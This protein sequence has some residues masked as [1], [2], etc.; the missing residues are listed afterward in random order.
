MASTQ[1]QLESNVSYHKSLLGQIAQLEYAPSSL[2]SQQGFLTG[3]KNDLKLSEAE[4]KT[5]SEITSKERKEHQ[6]LKDSVARKFTAKVTGRKEKFAAR[7]EKEEREYVQALEKEMQ[8]RHHIETLKKLISE[9]ETRRDELIKNVTEHEKLKHD[10]HALYSHI[11]DG[12]TQG[13]PQDDILEQQVL[14]SLTEHARIQSDYDHEKR[15]GELLDLAKTKMSHFWQAID[16][17]LSASTWDMFG[18]G[19]IAD[20]MERSSLSEAQ[21]YAHQATMF[22]QQAHNACQLVN[23][24]AIDGLYIAEG[25]VIGDIIFDNIY[26]DMKFH[27]KI[28]DS[29]DSAD[30]VLRNLTSERQASSRRLNTVKNYLNNAE[31]ELKK[32]RESLDTFRRGV[33]ESIDGGSAGGSRVMYQPPEGPPP[34]GNFQPPVGPPPNYEGGGV[35]GDGMDKKGQW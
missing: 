19:G 9:G 26:S 21:G 29:R 7:Q 28:Q 18:G 27:E 22:V 33:F 6:G 24:K 3:L 31:E 14:Q 4:V 15:A 34:S 10:L 32:R 23:P 8:C 11:F 17:A 2:E 1:A 13:Y 35:P 30:Q 5:L 16:A 25:S 12:P 20:M